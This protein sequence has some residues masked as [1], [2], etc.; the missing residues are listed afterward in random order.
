MSISAERLRAIRNNIPIADIIR[1]RLEL[2]NTFRDSFLRFL[3]PL[4]SG[5]DTA[6]N[7]ATNLARCFACKK[8][9]NPIDLVIAV[10]RCSFLDA[11]RFLQDSALPIGK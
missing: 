2:P 4:C 1:L 9:F 6:V 10:R 7:P 11:V 8:N 5:F 3:C